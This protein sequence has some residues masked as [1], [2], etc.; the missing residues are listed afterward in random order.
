[1][2]ISRE[3]MLVLYVLETPIFVLKLVLLSSLIFV[4]MHYNMSY[5]LQTAP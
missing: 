2:L 5:Y 3:I 4:S 1:M